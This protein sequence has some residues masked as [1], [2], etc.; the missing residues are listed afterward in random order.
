MSEIRVL[1]V[2]DHR[3]FADAI[4]VLLRG[5]PGITWAGAAA[6]GEEAMDMVA[7]GCPDV[8]LMDIDLPGMDG[9]EATRRL[10]EICPD[11]RVVAI[12]ALQPDRVLTRVIEA[13]AVGFVAKSRAAD[14]LLK[15]I[16]RAAAGEIVLPEH[17]LPNVLH[18]L[19]HSKHRREESQELA[20]R[21]TSREIQILEAFTG[22]RNTQEV[23]QA[24]VLSA[25]TVNSH[26][27]S[28]MA[29]LGVRSKLEAVLFAL[30]NGAIQ[31]PRSDPDETGH[32]DAR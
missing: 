6:S 5:E 26:L 22:G 28:V 8:V 18:R 4:E 31:L 2:D 29:K 1:V 30:R 14:E 19:Q 3:M 16:L 25:H 9:V 10:L 24:L 23:A 32:T 17:D 7:A 15:T 12:S 13:G 20:N 11:S 21:L 27:R